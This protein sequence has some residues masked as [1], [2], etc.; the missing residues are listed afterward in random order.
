MYFKLLLLYIHKC[1]CLRRIGG[2][3]DWLLFAVA[4]MSTRQFSSN[5]PIDIVQL[6]VWRINGELIGHLNTQILS[7]Q[8][9]KSIKKVYTVLRRS[10][11]E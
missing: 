9:G 11:E 7:L 4:I 1:F 3:L 6:S 2:I 5:L 8:T 10:F